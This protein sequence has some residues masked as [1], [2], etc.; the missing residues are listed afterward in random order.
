MDRCFKLENWYSKK[1]LQDIRQSSLVKII[2]DTRDKTI[3]KTI[4][5]EHHRLEDLEQDQRELREM[6]IMV[7]KN[8]FSRQVKQ[9]SSII[10]QITDF[11]FFKDFI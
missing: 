2:R 10:E 5:K 3:I 9:L 8:K 6:K 7:F 1:Y 11:F 4:M